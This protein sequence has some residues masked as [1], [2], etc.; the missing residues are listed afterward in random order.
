MM[1]PERVKT[2]QVSR[3]LILLILPLFLS[4]KTHAS[5]FPERADWGALN[6]GMGGASAA[7]PGSADGFTT[8]PAT[9]SAYQGKS[10]LGGSYQLLPHDLS[11]WSTTILDG[12][13]GLVGGFQFQW[14]DAGDPQRHSY[15]VAAAYRTEMLWVGASIYAQQFNSVR[16][17]KGWHLSGSSGI[18][19]P[20]PGGLSLG[21]YGKNFLDKENDHEL[22]PS[23]NIGLAYVVPQTLRAVV[24]TSR[25]FAL[26]NQNWNL[27]SGLELLLHEFFALKGGYHWN[28]SHEDSFWSVGGAVNG[29]KADA[30]FT[31]HQTRK[32]AAQGYSFDLGLKF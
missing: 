20:V 11:S 31:F 21:V 4:G 14:V 12:T 19:I 7:I 22:P 16:P 23:V 25:R 13:S 5:A 2:P 18:Y 3:L 27:S 1:S 32:N 29:P 8:N 26:P 10:F 6:Y 30:S 15:T 17:G 24:E 9:L 28:R